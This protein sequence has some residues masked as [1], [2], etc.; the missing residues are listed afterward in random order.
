MSF[1]GLSGSLANSSKLEN[2][3]LSGKF[4]RTNLSMATRG[5]LLTGHAQSLPPALG[6]M[7]CCLAASWHA[8]QCH[9]SARSRRPG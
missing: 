2:K 7:H 4:A 6:K 1:K 3:H 5:Q 9:R 8:L